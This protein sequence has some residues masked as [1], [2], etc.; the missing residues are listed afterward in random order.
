MARENE[1]KFFVE[2]PTILRKFIAALSPTGYEPRR[3][4]KRWIY[5]FPDLR[6]NSAKA[7]IRLREEED[8][9]TLCYK[10]RES[11]AMGGTLE[12]EIEVSDRENCAMILDSLGL[13]V[14]TYQETRREA[15]YLEGGV[16]ITIDE[17]P[18][19]PPICE[20][21]APNE[22]LVWAVL[23]K[24]GVPSNACV[25]D[26]TEFMYLLAFGLPDTMENRTAVS[27]IPHQAFD[28]ELPGFLRDARSKK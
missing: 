16:M 3:L 18:W 20:I 1:V 25:T 9:I 7:W 6:L 21:E 23:S 8:R 28:S 17:W 22:D 13:T 19:L 26:T 14:K 15:W 12:Y 27:T 11:S 10:R 5:D 24:M 2:D 4:M